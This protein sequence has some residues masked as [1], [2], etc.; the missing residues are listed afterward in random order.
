MELSIAITVI[1]SWQSSTRVHHLV[2]SLNGPINAAL[3]GISIP[4]MVPLIIFGLSFG[5]GFKYMQSQVREYWH[6][7]TT[8]KICDSQ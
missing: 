6:N 8:T 2:M 3:V 4:F 5:S 7:L 1:I